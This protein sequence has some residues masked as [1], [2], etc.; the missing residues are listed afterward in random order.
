MK[1]KHKSSDPL[2]LTAFIFFGVTFTVTAILL[3]VY[4]YRGKQVEKETENIRE[5]YVA[6][7]GQKRPSAKE[8]AEEEDS[9][10]AAAEAF[11]AM[12][13][14]NNDYIGWIRIPDTKIDNPVVQRDN[15]YYLNHT[16]TGEKNSH[17]TI[18]L[19]ESCDYRSTFYIL[20]GHHMKDGTMFHD[21]SKF[22]KK[23]FREEHPEFYVD[24]SYGEVTYHIF[25]V[26]D[27]DLTKE[28]FF[29][30]VEDAKT[31][32]IEDYLDR[33]LKASFWHEEKDT[34]PADTH[35]VLLST[36]DYGTEEQRLVVCG[37]RQ[38]K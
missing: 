36:C 23:D 17:G 7:V 21:L 14:V 1:D 6:I 20:H 13:S 22:K 34:I 25:A 37:Y 18:F 30:Y 3:F 31:A 28:G 29:N 2:L 15:D 19:D 16:I 8:I 27:V 33:L 9:Y 35:F 38:D 5:Q 32:E 26:M 12:K 10:S 24:W 11:N 4:Y